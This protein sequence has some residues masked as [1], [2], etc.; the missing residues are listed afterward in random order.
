MYNTET[1]QWSAKGSLAQAIK[2]RLYHSSAILLPSCQVMASGSDVSSWRGGGAGWGEGRWCCWRACLAATVHGQH[3]ACAAQQHSTAATSLCCLI[4][5]THPTSPAAP[6]PQVTADTTAEFFSPPSL[7]LPGRPSISRVGQ[8]PENKPRIVVGDKI[9]VE[10]KTNAPV[11]RALLIRTGATTHSMP[12]GELSGSLAVGRCWDAGC[13]AQHSGMGEARRAPLSRNSKDGML[14]SLPSSH[15]GAC[16]S[17]PPPMQ[18]PARSGCPL[19]TA[20]PA[21]WCCSCPTPPTC[22]SPACE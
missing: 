1:N 13:R 4:H 5:P 10:V 17:Q 22:S 14:H 2:P 8:F 16:T 11:Q 9:V 18:M 20:C 21:A 3:S 15:L 7:A 19:W 12:F 6:L